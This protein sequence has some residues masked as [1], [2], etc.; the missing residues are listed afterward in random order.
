MA[1]RN[2]RTV[3]DDILQKKSRPVE[4]ID[5]KICALLDDMLETMYHEGGVG[6][7]AV[8]VG[9]LRRVL[10][11]DI[12]EEQDD[13]IEMINPVV[14]HNEGEQE[15]REGCLSVPGK[16]GLVTRPLATSARAQNRHGNEFELRME[17]RMA[18]VFNHELDHLDGILYTDKATDICDNDD[19]D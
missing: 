17:G 8:Q 9:T 12:S 16:T 2:L 11:M 10:V 15:G 13:P 6:I 3:G 14:T 19:N 4:N 18:V 7:A 5:S 1:L